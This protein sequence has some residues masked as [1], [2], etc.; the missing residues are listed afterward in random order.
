MAQ[1]SGDEMGGWEEGEGEEEGW[2]DELHTGFPTGQSRR[3]A[4]KSPKTEA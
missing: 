2:E 1:L 4:A 3:H